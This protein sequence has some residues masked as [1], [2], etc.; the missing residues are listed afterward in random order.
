MVWSKIFG[1]TE[2]VNHPLCTTLWNADHEEKTFYDIRNTETQQCQHLQFEFQKSVI[3]FRPYLQRTRSV[4]ETYKNR[5]KPLS[6]ENEKYVADIMS[7][8]AF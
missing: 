7:I 1:K 4:T 6:F 5:F 8:H 2:K 3:G